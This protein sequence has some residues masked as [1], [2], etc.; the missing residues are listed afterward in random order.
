MAAVNRENGDNVALAGGT[1]TRPQPSNGLAG[2]SA[3]L[4]TTGVS[5][6]LAFDEVPAYTGRLAG[7]RGRVAEGG[8]LLKRYTAKPYRGFESLRLRHR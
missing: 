7:R 6:S 5:G 8:A 4:T 2:P 3:K 1:A